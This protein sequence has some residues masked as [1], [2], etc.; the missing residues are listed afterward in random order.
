[1][2]YKD[3]LLTELLELTVKRVRLEQSDFFQHDTLVQDQVDTMRN[4]EV[5]LRERI[6]RIMHESDYGEVKEVRGKIF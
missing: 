4:Y 2:N 3:E 5:I 6:L 1:M